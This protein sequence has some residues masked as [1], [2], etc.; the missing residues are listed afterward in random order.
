MTVSA[1]FTCATC[2]GRA[3]T[4]TLLE[5][6]DPVPDAPDGP[7]GTPG[8]G[9]LTAAAFPDRAQLVIEGGPVSKAVGF[10]P[11]FVVSAALA[12]GD[13]ALLYAIDAELAPFWCPRCEAAY[14]ADHYRSWVTFDEGFYDATYGECPEGH[15]RMLDD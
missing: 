12:G 11:P 8:L 10:V 3:A 7:P 1:T 4:V 9:A 6:G 2:G 13:A 14:C 15:E 5:P